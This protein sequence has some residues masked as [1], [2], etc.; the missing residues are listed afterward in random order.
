MM[1]MIVMNES[2]MMLIDMLMFEMIGSIFGQYYN[3]NLLPILLYKL[4]LPLQLIVEHWTIESIR[5]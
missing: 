5:Y 2:L 3:H 4:E 1:M